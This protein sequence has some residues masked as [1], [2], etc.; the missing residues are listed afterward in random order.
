MAAYALGCTSPPAERIAMPYFAVRR[1]PG[2]GWNP[3]LAMREQAVWPEHATFM[4]SHVEEG[5]VLLGG[6]LR[7]GD[8]ILLII[9]AESSENVVRR[10][11]LDPWA[12]S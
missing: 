11:A 5:F 10:F 2:P 3:T 7:T 1:A 9:Q 12:T 6:P 4:N 8:E